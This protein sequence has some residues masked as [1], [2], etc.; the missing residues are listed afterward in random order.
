MRVLVTGGTGL[1]GPPLI[2]QL[3]ARGDEVLALTRRPAEVRS[4]LAE[5]VMLVE[6]DPT[7]AGPRASPGPPP[8]HTEDARDEARQAPGPG[9]KTDA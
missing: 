6:G 5:G 2:G 3:R 8:Q 4:R 7:R 9:V 1:V